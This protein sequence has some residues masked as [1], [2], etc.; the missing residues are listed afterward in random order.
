MQFETGRPA[1]D[2]TKR[3]V[4][5]SLPRNYT[6][7]L[8]PPS[9][10]VTTAAGA[11]TF[12]FAVLLQALNGVAAVSTLSLGRRREGAAQGFVAELSLSALLA[13]H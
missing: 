9:H 5:R 3:L 1:R 11:S 10:R 8:P 2:F 13:K 4:C 12:G 6:E 7:P